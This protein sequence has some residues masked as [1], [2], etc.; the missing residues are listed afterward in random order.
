MTLGGRT[1]ALTG[2]VSR[3]AV[4]NILQIEGRKRINKDIM[5]SET[6]GDK[7]EFFVGF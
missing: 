4:T 2:Q 1:S 3:H 5:G 7:G 6:P